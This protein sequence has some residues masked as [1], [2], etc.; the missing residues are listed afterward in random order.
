MKKILILTLVLAFS[1]YS[2]ISHAQKR[3][4]GT[5]VFLELN[6]HSEKLKDITGWYHNRG[7]DKWVE[8]KNLIYYRPYTLPCQLKQNVSWVQMATTTY[9]NTKYYVLL[10]ERKDGEYYMDKLTEDS[11]TEEYWRDC[12]KTHFF[13]MTELQ[14]KEFKNQI[15]AKTGQSQPITGYVG[16]FIEDY[17]NTVGIEYSCDQRSLCSEITKELKKPNY[18]GSKD[19]FT[20]N[21]QVVDGIEVVRFRVPEFI[22]SSKKDSESLN[23]KMQKDG[24]FE[25]DFNDFKKIFIDEYAASKLDSL[26]VK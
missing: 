24:Y 14:Y 22:S 18:P 21:S 5:I 20:Y 13:V 7:I 12:R 6:N 11:K 25:V 4:E 19:C 9:E 3:V 10:Y 8:N 26:M 17:Y 2:I 15:N 16:G 23:K 1:F